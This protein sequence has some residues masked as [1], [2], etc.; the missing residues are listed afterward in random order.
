MNKQKTL[1]ILRLWQNDERLFL[2]SQSRLRDDKPD[3]VLALLRQRGLEAGGEDLLA[4]LDVQWILSKMNDPDGEPQANGGRFDLKDKLQQGLARVVEQIDAGYA[5]VMTMYTVAFYLGVAL[6][7]VSVFAAFV[8]DSERAAMV[9][10][11]LGMA[12]IL[13]TM[14]FKPAQEVQ[15]SRG[16]LAQLQAAFFSWFNDVFNWNQ[17]LRLLG[18]DAAGRNATPDFE[19]LH[20]VSEA[21]MQNVARMMSLIEEYCEVRAPRGADADKTPPPR[22]GHVRGP[23]PPPEPAAPPEDRASQ[24]E[25]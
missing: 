11:G 21:Q 19:R 24:D 23:T 15:N 8:L 18:D 4:A 16:N 20:R 14:I 22:K 5:R 3:A 6:V 12:D 13:A 2:D 17:Y 9:M 10:G 7:L 25:T 1:G